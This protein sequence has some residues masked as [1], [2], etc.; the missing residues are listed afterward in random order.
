MAGEARAGTGYRPPRGRLAGR[1]PLRGRVVAGRTGPGD[2][3][4]HRRP[5]TAAGVAAGCGSRSPAGAVPGDP[6][7][8]R[9]G[10]RQGP[11]RT[12]RTARLEGAC[13]AERGCV[14]AHPSRRNE[15]G[16]RNRRRARRGRSDRLSGLV[17]WGDSVG[18][19]VFASTDEARRS[20]VLGLRRLVALTTPDPTNWVVSR[21]SNPVK[22]ALAAS[23]Y[24]TV[25][26]L[27][28]DA[29]LKAIDTLLRA[30]GEPWLVRDEQAFAALRDR[31]RSD[32]AD[33]MLATVNTTGEVLQRHQRVLL[34][35]PSAPPPVRADVTE[36]LAGLVHRGFIAGTPDPHWQRLPRYLQAIEVRVVASRADPARDAVNA[37]IIDALED[38]YA[39]VCSG[40]PAGPLP[41]DVAEVGWLLEELRVSLFAQSLGTAMP[42]SAKRVRTAMAG[43]ERVGR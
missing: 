39:R 21:L 14:R 9:S 11:A 7:R 32:A 16:L 36:Q 23:P 1:A 25:P 33:H 19:T 29:R 8:R 24:P 4:A 40:Y 43:I 31:V 12:G 26:A 22:F 34:D 17:G 42:V 27:L 2:P 28:A 37:E 38:Q 3:A 18:V 35:L 5:G 41:T 20:H 30:A 13:R 6:R 15:L 10:H